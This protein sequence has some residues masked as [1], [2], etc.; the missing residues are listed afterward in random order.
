MKKLSKAGAA[1]QMGHNRRI[2]PF[3]REDFDA[4]AKARNLDP[5]EKLAARW[6]SDAD[7]FR[8]NNQPEMAETLERHATELRRAMAQAK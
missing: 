3:D 1:A 4:W 8:R 5:V 7:A 6:L 2:S